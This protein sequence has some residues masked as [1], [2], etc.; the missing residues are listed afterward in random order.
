MELLARKLRRRDDREADAELFNSWLFP[1]LN[2][3]PPEGHATPGCCQRVCRLLSDLQQLET[4]RCVLKPLP[5]D[6]SDDVRY[7]W[8]GL[9]FLHR[10][11]DP[12]AEE[13]YR[14]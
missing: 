1:I 8:S 6:R 14:T 7:V 4:I 13:L 11:R 12:K 3:E 10:F 5:R 2:G 9:G